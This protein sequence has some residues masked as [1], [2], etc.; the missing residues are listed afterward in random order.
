MKSYVFTVREDICA[1]NGKDVTATNLL[2]KMKLYGSVEDFDSVI[3][4]GKA[5]YQ[6]AVDNL[7]AQLTAIS[8]QKLTAE[9]IKLVKVYRDCKNSTDKELLAKIDSLTKQLEDIKA[10]NESRIEKIRAAIDA[11]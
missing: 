10:E 6:L 3:A 11:K 1:A 4:K 8:E 7:K 5:E 2:E 9:E